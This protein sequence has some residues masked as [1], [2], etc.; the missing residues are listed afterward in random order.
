MNMVT[1]RDRASLWFKLILLLVVVAATVLV[2]TREDVREFFHKGTPEVSSVNM[3][4]DRLVENEVFSLKIPQVLLE[5]QLDL[6]FDLLKPLDQ[7][8]I[9]WTHAATEATQQYTLKQFTSGQTEALYKIDSQLG[10]ILPGKNDYE[11]IGLLK[12]DG[13]LEPASRIRFSLDLDL[14]KMAELQPEWISF[15]GLAAETDVDALEINGVLKGGV[16]SLQSYS[17]HPKTGR[18]TF[19]PLSRYVAGA[20][21]FQYRLSDQLGN[22][23]S[24]DNWYVI[25]ALDEQKQIVARKL[26]SLKSTK[27][28]IADEVEELFGS[29]TAVKGGW[30]VSSRLPWFSVRPVFESIWYPEE[31]GKVLM[32]RPTLTYVAEAMRGDS[33]CDYLK[34]R[35]YQKENYSYYGYSYETCQKFHFGVTVY[36]RFQ[37]FLKYQPVETVK[38]LEY[39]DLTKSVSSAFVMI[40]TGAMKDHEALDIGEADESFSDEEVPAEKAEDDEE[41]VVPKYYIY[42]L[43][44]TDDVPYEGK[45]VGEIAVEIPDEKKADFDR[46]RAL[47]DRFSGDQ[48]FTTLLFPEEVKKGDTA[49]PAPEVAN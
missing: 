16:Q 14:Q 1:M 33:F 38:R 49:V 42:Q 6:R 23:K 32:P 48:L 43:S 35:E 47:L 30:F 44:I 3:D 31:E 40:E 28:T 22:L 21:D 10:N 20:T 9:V 39:K 45:K 7:I 36:D 46:V 17:F 11:I 27:M 34:S 41:V 4:A 8:D 29:F 5:A 2:L 18:S 26:F 13:A 25:E 15:P 19:A 24:G 37:S 12:K